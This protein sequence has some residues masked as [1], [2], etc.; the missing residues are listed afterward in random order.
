MQITGNNNYLSLLYFYRIDY[1]TS[2]KRKRTE[3][4][5]SAE[6]QTIPKGSWA[7]HETTTLYVCAEL[8]LSDSGFMC[9]DHIYTIYN[10]IVKYQHLQSIIKIRSK[11]IGEIKAKLKYMSYL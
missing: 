2:Y 6:D 7:L 8:T 3:E 10:F 4:F 9:L 11:S 1:Y 5:L